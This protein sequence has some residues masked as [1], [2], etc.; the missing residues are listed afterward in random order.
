MLFAIVFCLLARV[1][2]GLMRAGGAF[3]IVVWADGLFDLA[4]LTFVAYYDI[5]HK[6][7]DLHVWR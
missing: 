3:R 7:T 5:K 2:L 4:S 1:F 6:P